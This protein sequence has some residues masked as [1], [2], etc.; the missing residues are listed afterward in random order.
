MEKVSVIVPA[1]NVESYIHRA[2]ES[3]IGQ[4]YE[5]VELVV[6]DD[7]S[8]DNTWNII[9][10]YAKQDV[11][12]KAIRQ[13]NQGV[14]A[15]RNTALDALTGDYAVFLD[16]DDWL[17]EGTIEYLIKLQTT[18]EGLLVA[19]SAYFVC[20]VNGAIYKKLQKKQRPLSIVDAREAIMNIGTDKYNL[21]SSCYKLFDA[22]QIGTLRF[23]TTIYHGEDGLFVFEYLQKCSG[24]VFS[25]EP[26][27]NIL[28][29]PESTTRAS[30]NDKWLTAI[31]AAEK[32]LAYAYDNEIND[33]LVLNIIDR[34]Q[35]I[36]KH[37]LKGLEPNINAVR[38][39]KEI[40]KKY[41]QVFWSKRRTL[42]LYVKYFVYKC[43]PIWML[44]V[45]VNIISILKKN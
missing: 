44:K 3:V 34:A 21:R 4:T 19:G 2:I 5:N 43:M 31:D 6:V 42:K 27:W 16:S 29:R 40:Q 14:S 36:E 37:A 22:R 24:L 32:M 1:Y 25:T 28:M 18:H 10:K 26:L 15:A 30:Y 13:K 20:D 41:A 8:E 12:I 38:R 9:K 11:R 35:I 39:A 17:E 7:G 33:A 23:D 45:V